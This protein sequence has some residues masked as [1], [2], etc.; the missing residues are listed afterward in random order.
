MDYPIS[1]VSSFIIDSLVEKLKESPKGCFVEV[2]V[3]KGGT[4]KILCKGTNKDTHLLL[5]DT[6]KYLNNNPVTLQNLTFNQFDANVGVIGETLT[7]S[8]SPPPFL[9][10]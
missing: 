1:A 5:F 3:Y 7:P 4:A 10:E 9:D 6:F 8:W 2:G